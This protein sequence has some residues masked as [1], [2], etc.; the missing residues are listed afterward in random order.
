LD[1]YVD[2]EIV[3]ALPSRFPINYSLLFDR[4]AMP[5][6]FVDRQSRFMVRLY[7]LRAVAVLFS[8]VALFI[9]FARI[10]RGTGSHGSGSAVE[11]VNLGCMD[12]RL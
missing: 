6:T 11:F 1:T 9:T 5:H 12:A 8:G 4:G 7:S 3:A 10:V 2:R